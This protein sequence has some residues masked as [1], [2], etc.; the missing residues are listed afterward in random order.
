M[1]EELIKRLRA[2]NASLL[3]QVKISDEQWDA[4]ND[5]IAAL[6]AAGD[7]LAVALAPFARAEHIVASVETDGRIRCILSY[8]VD[9]KATFTLALLDQAAE[10]AKAWQEA[11]GEC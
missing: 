2:D 9:A 1:S 5:R 8:P 3:S 11:R 7:K 4:W 6:I 10:A